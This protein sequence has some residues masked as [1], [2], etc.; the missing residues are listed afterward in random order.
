MKN[1]I[2]K[3]L[4]EVADQKVNKI[5]AKVDLFD[6]RLV[7]AGNYKYD[8]AAIGIAYSTIQNDPNSNKYI[9]IGE[10]NDVSQYWDIFR[11]FCKNFSEEEL[12]NTISNS[13]P[14]EENASSVWNLK[15]A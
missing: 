10:S 15:I 4:L 9:L 3:G 12:P 5:G 13:T 14:E 6:V 2:V 1:N 11:D 8:Y 7:F